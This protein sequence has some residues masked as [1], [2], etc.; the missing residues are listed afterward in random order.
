MNALP[1]SL[2]CGLILSLALTIMASAPSWA[3]P[4]ALLGGSPRV[5]VAG[6]SP[7]GEEQAKPMALLGVGPRVGV[8]GNSPLGE[9]QK[10]NFQMYD[11]AAL[12]R[13]PWGWW[14][15]SGA[16]GLETRLIASAGELTAAG[17]TSLMATLVPGL[18]V[19]S[20]NGAVSIDVGVGPGFF[21]NYKF[22][23]QDFGGPVQIVG[24]AGIGF[25]L[26]PGFH[27][28]Y[29]FQHFSDAGIYGATSLGVDM[30]ILE[31][32]YRF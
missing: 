7:V 19:T 23:V 8:G 26:L 12:F 24:T 17:T 21:S 32:A 16:W 9:E 30:H 29:R 15:R 18:A 25:N 3:E 20:R 28:G 11:V 4:M 10:E 2:T 14:H 5:G 22:G 31:I 1:R 6:V 13:L 27:A